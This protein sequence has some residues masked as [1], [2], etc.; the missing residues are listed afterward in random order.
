MTLQAVDRTLCL[1]VFIDERVGGSGGYQQ[2][3]N[4]AVLAS[5]AAAD[6][7][8]VLCVTPHRENLQVLTT[9]G[10]KAAHLPYSRWLAVRLA[11]RRRIHHPR[12]LRMLRRWA[13][14]NP[15]ERFIEAQE[16]DLVYFTSPAGLARDL[17]RTS[18]LVTIWDLCHRDHPEFPEVRDD[19]EFERRE[20]YCWQV[21]PKAVAVFADS[22]L[23]AQNLVRRYG[24]DP[25]RVRV[26]PFA[27]STQATGDK[28]GVNIRERFGIDG[29]YVFYP[30]QFWAHKNHVYILRALALLRQKHGVRLHAVFAGRDA[31]N[32]AH[33][34]SQAQALELADCVHFAGFVAGSELPEFYRQALALVMPT[35]FGP[36][37]LP[38]LEALHH[39]TPVVYPRPL[40]EASGLES[41]VRCIDLDDP[42]SL[43]A[44]LLSLAKAERDEAQRRGDAARDALECLNDDA[45]RL[46]VLES[47]LRDF[48][49]KRSSWA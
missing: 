39:S 47:V 48:A 2:S 35:Y 45:P 23:G 8:R 40:A 22:P 25:E 18:F 19:R 49:R 17:E 41:V 26:M 20:R 27:P 7:W 29:D 33:V 32:M 34:R 21:L 4:A 31:G 24:L 36:T 5:K 30:A 14:A 43:V 16:I 11:L 3:L 9:M 44:V 1:G 6:G 15:L 42:E 38:P 10:L 13:G 37:N 28:T 12:L 46:A